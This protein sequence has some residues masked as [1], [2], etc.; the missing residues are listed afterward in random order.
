MKVSSSQNLF[1]QLNNITGINQASS[2]QKT[3]TSS[4]ST[5]QTQT[6]ISQDG[7]YLSIM[8][9]YDMHNISY[10][11]MKSMAGQLYS[12]NLIDERSYMHMTKPPGDFS[13]IT[14]QAKPSLDE[15]YD[16]IG[17]YEDKLEF[18]KTSG[19]DPQSIAFNEQ[20][21][22]LFRRLEDYQS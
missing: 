20:M 3:M 5:D 12:S 17:Y 8:S 19:A 14:G 13:N 2:H 10:N 7:Q 1:T 4:A 16:A 6:K 11:E 22:S 9:K 15:A 21:L 18:Q